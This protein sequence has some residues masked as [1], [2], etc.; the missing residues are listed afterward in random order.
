MKKSLKIL[1]TTGFLIVC[2][3]L[4]V[5][6]VAKGQGSAAAA[7]NNDY[8][9]QSGD[10]LLQNDIF[11]SLLTNKYD[12]ISVPTIFGVQMYGN[13]GSSSPYYPSMI[14]SN[15]SWVRVPISWYLIEPVKL[16]P[17]E[18][19]WASVDTF[20]QA[21]R[22]DTGGLEFIV[23]IG[24]NPGWAAEHLNGV[25]DPEDVSSYT[26]FIAAAVERY[27]GDG[28]DDANGSPVVNHWEI[29][30]EPDAGGDSAHIRWGYDGDKYA[31][32][33]AAI[34]P[35]VKNANPAAQVVFG[36]MAYD[37]FEDNSGG[38]FVRGFIDDVLSAGGG[39]YFDVMNFHV[40]P[41]FWYNWTNQESPGLIE[42]STFI[43]NKLASY[44]YPNKPILITEAGWHSN[45]SASIPGDPEDQ[46]RYV[47][48]LFTQSI[49]VG[50]KT[51]VWWMLHDSVDN[52]Q[53]EN[54]LITNVDHVN[55]LQPKPSFMAFKTAVSVLGS[56]TFYRI[57]PDGQT[58]SSNMEAY[59]MRDNA[60]K[61][62]V[63]VAWMDPVDTSEV[64]PLRV[65]ASVARVR[66]IYG[67]SH[68]V[69]DG[70]DG[71]VDGLVTVSVGGQP[72][73]IEVDW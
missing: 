65:P 1:L 23:T 37:W 72:V 27:D 35:A 41:V 9:L 21:A 52:W 55:P 5:A 3:A 16:N 14:N 17:P 70:Q 11:L 8:T 47:V 22:P 51:M 44:G 62:T 18:Y 54:G 32:L 7:K 57:L 53:Y 56:A 43:K 66:T 68:V 36:G 50:A 59:E 2:A 61:R 34:Y 40:Y 46:A 31:Q 69:T 64:K 25:L 73:Y 49:A 71:N 13:T 67:D 10:D 19:N 48:E 58:G 20:T 33:L 45:S 39:A 12:A 29:Y 4:S 38:P 63:Y 24:G 60:L 26:A 28:I 15:T 42:K 6:V 30:N